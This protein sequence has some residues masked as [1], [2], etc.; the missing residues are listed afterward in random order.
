MKIMIF[1]KRGFTLV[2]VIVSIA[3]FGI[4][5]VLFL[6]VFFSSYYL[7]LRSEDRTQAVGIASGQLQNTLA[8]T[9][10][11]ITNSAVSIKYNASTTRVVT[12]ETTS[13]SITTENDQ[14]VTLEYFIPK[15]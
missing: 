8:T 13:K 7:T 15:K 4:M 11:A 14:T 1:D 9:K 3:I 10:S 12:G 5:A 2:E 6:N